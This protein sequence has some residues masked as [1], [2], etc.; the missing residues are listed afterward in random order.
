M[1]L[2][3]RSSLHL[4]CSKLLHVLVVPQQTRMY[5][6]LGGTDGSSAVQERAGAQG[7]DMPPL[8]GMLPEGAH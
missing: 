7:L 2:S 3:A 5:T 4:E 1:M 8:E 6:L